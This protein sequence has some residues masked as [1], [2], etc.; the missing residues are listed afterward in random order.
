MLKIGDFSR[1]ARVSVKALRFYDEAGFLKPA[2]VDAQSGYRYYS[3]QQLPR[4]NRIL[5]LKDLGLTLE[6]I[7]PLLDR[8]VGPAELCEALRR[9]RAEVQE[10]R[11]REDDLLRRVETRLRLLESEGQKAMSYDV[12]LK[13]IE[14]L[15]VAS[16]REV[17][18]SIE[19]M[20]DRS[21][22]LIGALFGFAVEAGASPS[23]PPFAVYYNP[24]YT[25][26]DIDMEMALPVQLPSGKRLP[27]VTT[28]PATSGSPSAL[29]L[30]PGT[31]QAA[32]VIHQGP[33]SGLSA[34]YA[35]GGAWIEANGYRMVG[36]IREIYLT[37]PGEGS[38]P[39][40]ELQFPVE[41]ASA[42]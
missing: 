17:V 11:D 42:A 18:P 35:E 30:L 12:V 27:E 10:R 22:A 29:R 33:Y 2:R 39:V 41:P 8:N 36:P 20:S 23:G 24:E 7:R 16:V 25:E 28:E 6:Q 21:C 38:I 26:Q 40:T 15:P 4:L 19:Q 3:M 9:K 5:A 1:L 13:S 31:A 37:G 34:A 32:C 14:P